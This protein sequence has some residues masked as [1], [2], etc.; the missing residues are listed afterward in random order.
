MEAVTIAARKKKI[1]KWSNEARLVAISKLT[2]TDFD[3][4]A[5]S[6][7]ISPV[8]LLT[9]CGEDDAGVDLQ[10]LADIEE[11][12]DRDGPLPAQVATDSHR[13]DAGDFS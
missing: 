11:G 10:G 4:P 6:L 7:G 13:G 9:G 3:M 5:G 8:L 2:A 1:T 12:G